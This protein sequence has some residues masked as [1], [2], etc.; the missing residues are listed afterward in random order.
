[1]DFIFIGDIVNTHGLKGEIRIQSEFKY[2]D[3][4]FKVGNKIYVGDNH[5]AVIIKSY[6]THKNYDMVS[7][8]DMNDIND[9][10]IYKGESAYV[11]R[12]DYVFPGILDEDVI[13]LDVIADGKIVGN[14]ETIMKT[15]AHGILVIKGKKQ[16]HLVPYIDEFIKNIDLDK[17]ILELNVIEGLIN[18]D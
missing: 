15:D 7:F 6:R 13:G 17:N 3:V 14:V 11:D 16:K 12:N 2:K 18:E 8:E 4:V 9:V 5:D 10:I 1:M